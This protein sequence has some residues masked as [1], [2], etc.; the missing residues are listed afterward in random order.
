VSTKL[1][2]TDSQDLASLVAYLYGGVE[3]TVHRID[4]DERGRAVFSV[5]VPSCDFEILQGELSRDEISVM[6]HSFRSVENRL[7]F[8][9]RECKRA[10][11]SWTSGA[12]QRGEVD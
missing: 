2:Q 9:I 10:G 1:V 5:L 12:W 8:F 11:G 7:R 6:L 3:E 4:L